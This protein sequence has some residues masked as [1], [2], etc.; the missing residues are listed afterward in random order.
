M[1][2][3]DILNL[4]LKKDNEELQRKL[5]NQEDKEKMREQN[6]I[7]RENYLKKD[8]KH[9]DE[10]KDLSKIKDKGIKDMYSEYLMKM[11]HQEEVKEGLARIEK[12]I[13]PVK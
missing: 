5:K 10:Y 8:L 7:A 13:S 2:E 3:V 11:G 9:R 1:K 6:L 4:E 12:S